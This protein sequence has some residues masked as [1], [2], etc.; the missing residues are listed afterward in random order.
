MNDWSGR[1]ALLTAITVLVAVSEARGQV[2][3]GTISGTVKDSTGAVLP[4]VAV[5]AQHLETGSGR[6][7][8]TDDSGRFHLP[9]LALGEY[10]LQAELAGFQT[11]V[12]KG[13]TLTVGR[14]LEVTFALSVGEITEK[15]E[16]SGEAP[17]VETTTAAISGLVGEKAIRD[18]P[19]N[20]RT[21]DQLVSLQSGSYSFKLGSDNFGGGS[22]G[23]FSIAG[24]RVGSNRI[25]IDGT[26]LQG[27]SS[28]GYG[29]PSG[30]GVEAIR[31][32]TVV[33]NAY[34]AEIGKRAG[35]VVNVAT[36]SGT[37]QLHGS[38]FEFHRNDNLDARNFFD[39]GDL[40]EFKR[41][42]FGAAVG[43]PIVRDRSFFF[44]NYEGVRQG[45]GSTTIA[46][47]PD[48]KARQGL[49]PEPRT[50]GFRQV[51]VA[52]SVKPYL[53]LYPLPN[54]RNNGDGTAEFISGPTSALEQNF[55][56]VKSDYRFSEADSIF[57]TYRFSTSSAFSPF[58]L[59]LFA[60]RTYIRTQL[61][62]LQETRVFSPRTLNTLRLGGVRSH[63]VDYGSQPL[64]N[65]DPRLSFAEGLSRFGDIR[66]GGGASGGQ[67][68]L[69]VLGGATGDDTGKTDV[70]FSDQL[71]YSSG[72]H[73]LKAGLEVQRM[74]TNVR[75][76]SISVSKLGTYTFSSLDDFLLGQAS[77]F[78]IISGDSS[79]G[80]RA[81]YAGFYIQD[82]L[83]LRPDFTLNLGLRY[84]FTTLLNE[85]SGKL[86]NFV[87][88]RIGGY[89]VFETVPRIGKT[90]FDENN[91]LRGFGP[92]I[93]F[94]WNVLG[95]GK[96][97]VRSGFGMFYD[98]FTDYAIFT[99]TN[100]PFLNNYS[101]DNPTFPR[102]DLSQR[103]ALTPAP[104]GLDPHFDVPT[105]LHYNLTIQRE[106]LPRTTLTVGY[107]GSR[108]YHLIGSAQGNAAIPQIQPDG[109]KFFPAGAPRRNPR[110]GSGRYVD[111]AGTYHYD[112][113]QL[114]LERT[115]SLGL[116]F[117]GSYTWSKNI[118]NRSTISNSQA[119][120]TP[121]Q[122]L[123]P[124]D[125]APDRSLSAF[126]LR[127]NF[128][129]NYT[130]D[131]PRRESGAFANEL[132]AGWQLNGITS[133][134]SGPPFTPK[135]GF[136]RSRNGDT[137]T[138][139]R[140]NL[141]PGGSGNP[142]LGGADRYFDV[143]A[144]ELQPPGFF[145]NAGRNSIIGPGFVDFDFA[146]VKNLSLHR[147][148][149]NLGVQVRFEFFNAF[150]RAN[151]GIPDALVFNSNGTPRPAGARI[152]STVSTSRQIQLGLKVTF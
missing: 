116:R 26:E 8:I 32:F 3:L 55:F 118:D 73:S 114:S 104:D 14:E 58:G 129:F 2:T 138:P 70:Q 40:P 137:R 97:S 103:A 106:F 85:V 89:R 111:A 7:M 144:F 130:Y 68:A 84:E 150:N 1:L 22:S 56:L 134:T 102:M 61:F 94:A 54:G 135:L 16:V 46:V 66:I 9:Q 77:N 113:L 151:F 6:T 24:A 87:S 112:S 141:R 125:I 29:T 25:L 131:L 115:Y 120:N 11:A 110:L 35:G 44:A 132:I 149:E 50:G 139:D 79:R 36:R 43:G 96:T 108:G 105:S 63:I 67:T 65:L 140:P 31:E 72:P 127:H 142:V 52:E 18:L 126:D 13:I 38:V 136:N 20:G 101:I 45:L 59:E 74:H 19:L 60:G 21:F 117:K 82:D 128:A 27:G 47:V 42:N 41:H 90:L 17:L 51:S 83:K 145:G 5:K 95:D 10:E 39:P 76:P 57:A 75:A 81:T 28:M 92:R 148:S 124:D 4:G 91:S 80:L 62:T 123:D 119:A 23:N 15:V 121:Q 86:S 143:A 48:D 122:M 34:S 33:M 49:L 100:V 152:R 146:A 64:V 99:V 30:L 12:R 107:V 37:N 53:A 109:R 71:A 147:V 78:R 133:V 98:Q 88:T 69:T 93:G